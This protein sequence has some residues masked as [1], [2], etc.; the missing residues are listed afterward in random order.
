MF[1]ARVPSKIPQSTGYCG[2]G[3]EDHLVLIEYGAKKTTLRDDFPL[4]SCLNSVTLDNDGDD[5][6]LKSL[7]LSPSKRSIGFRWLADADDRQHTL[8]ILNGKFV[9]D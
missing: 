7:L 3:Y 8:T 5:D 2:A 1:I 4:Q 9:L 6:I